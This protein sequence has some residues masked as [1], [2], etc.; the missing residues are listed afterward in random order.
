[1]LLAFVGSALARGELRGI[2][3][4][5]IAFCAFWRKLR[6]EERWMREQF[7]AAYEDYRSRV[8]ALIPLIL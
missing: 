6:I 7:G 2:L 8:A 1:L 4:V 3:A 5:I